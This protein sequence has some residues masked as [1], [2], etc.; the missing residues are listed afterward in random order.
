MINYWN[1]PAYEPKEDRHR[2]KQPTR[3][4]HDAHTE[5]TLA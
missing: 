1:H 5:G 4:G 3:H 2:P